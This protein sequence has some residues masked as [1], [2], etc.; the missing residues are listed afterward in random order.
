MLLGDFAKKK[1]QDTHILVQEW[2]LCSLQWST[3]YVDFVKKE[4]F[5]PSRQGPK[6]GLNTEYLVWSEHV[7]EEGGSERMPAVQATHCLSNPGRA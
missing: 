6:S 1:P 3:R 5:P 2:D 7:D 4:C